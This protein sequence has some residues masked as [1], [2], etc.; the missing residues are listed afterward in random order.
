MDL[1]SEVCLPCRFSLLAQANPY[2]CRLSYMLLAW[3]TPMLCLRPSLA[4]A[5]QKAAK[6]AAEADCLP[7]AEYTAT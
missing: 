6:R 3:C 1:F 4:C 5:E 7:E 2:Q